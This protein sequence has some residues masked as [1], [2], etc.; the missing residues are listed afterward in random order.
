MK[1]KKMLLLIGGILLFVL[2]LIVTYT[3]FKYLQ[4]KD[5]LVNTLEIKLDDK[6]NKINMSEQVPHNDS[7][8][9]KITPYIFN[10]TNKGET[11]AYYELLLEDVIDQNQ[12]KQI[13]SRD[14][15]KYEL[16]LN[17]MVIKL[18]YLSNIKNNVI[19]KRLLESGKKSN[20]SLK[21]WVSNSVD[22]SSWM[23]KYYNYNISVNPVS[24]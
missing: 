23:N 15:L 6:N 21:V 11:N 5:Y 16:T 18:D 19:D 24:K 4:Q 1:K 10:V 7:D 17:G 13:L 3:S 8:I 20:Y 14:N 9:D 2:I 12:T 22:D